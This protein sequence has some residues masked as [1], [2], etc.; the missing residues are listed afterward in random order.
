MTEEIYRRM[1][2]WVRAAEEFDVRNDFDQS[3]IK[4]VDDFAKE[5]SAAGTR[6]VADYGE[7]LIEADEAWRKAN[8]ARAAQF[9]VKG[10]V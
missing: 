9:P 8:P 3:I 1:A 7:A 4:V 6:L 10:A 5:L 2:E